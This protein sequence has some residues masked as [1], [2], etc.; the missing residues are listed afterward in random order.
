MPQITINGVAFDPLALRGA[1]AHHCT[2]TDE[3]SSHALLATDT[4]L[5]AE[6]RALLRSRG[7]TLLEYVPDSAYIVTCDA[8]ARRAAQ[9][10]PFVSWIGAYP[11]EA[12]LGRTALPDGRAQVDVVLHGDVDARAAAPEVAAVAGVDLAQVTAYAGKLRLALRAAAAARL[13]ALDCVRHVELVSTKRLFGATASGAAG[14]AV[15]RPGHLEGEGEVIAVCDTGLD[16]GSISDVHPAFRK[17]VLRIYALA[18]SSGS[19]PHGHG[20]QSCSCALGDGPVGAGARV[21][22]VAPRAKL[23]VQSVLDEHGALCLPGHLGQLFEPPYRDE[24]ARVHSNAW[25]DDRGWYSAES[26]ETDEF[27]WQRRDAVVLFAAGAKPA[28]SLSLAKNCI[29][30]SCDEGASLAPQPPLMLR[31]PSTPLRAARSR[32]AGR[33]HAAGDEDPLY[34]EATG[35]SSAVSLAAGCAAV[36][37]EHLRKSR[38][39]P[40]A[41][42]VKALLLSGARHGYLDL[43]ASMLTDDTGL[44]VYWDEDRALDTGDV[45]TLEVELARPCALLKV[46]LVWTDPPGE[47]VQNELRVSVSRPHA[48]PRLAASSETFRAGNVEQLLFGAVEPGVVRLTVSALRA[49]IW[50]QSYALVLRAAFAP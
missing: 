9:R 30:V 39:S 33:A 44:V 24:G 12:K 36:L 46:T 23:V 16:V 38:V 4:A 28:S 50:P 34:G 48:P 42:L 17:R 2:S 27:I 8:R 35:A 13:T 22:G 45:E 3:G 5:R 43:T 10:L 6:Q 31:T 40:S 25:G 14:Q 15:N 1:A 21:R 41:A 29:A 19:D 37:R 26:R 18:R 7:V 49:A 11:G 20:T 47:S 32:A